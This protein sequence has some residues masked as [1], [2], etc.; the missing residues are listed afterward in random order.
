MYRRALWATAFAI[1]FAPALARADASIAGQWDADLGR[2]KL[3]SM[4]ILADGYWLSENVENGQKIGQMAGSYE[5]KTVN[6]TTGT[7]VFTPDAAK[8]HVN[9]AHGAARIE[10]DKYTLSQDGRLLRLTP[11]SGG[12]MEFHRQSQ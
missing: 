4:T 11:G 1:A 9:E 8:T 6:G 5:Q 12:V 10:T 2:G 3:I 7:L